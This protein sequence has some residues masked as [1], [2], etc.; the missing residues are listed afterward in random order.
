MIE[1]YEQSKPFLTP[2]SWQVITMK[3]EKEQVIWL[4]LTQGN[5]LV[6]SKSFRLE[7]GGEG[8]RREKGSAQTNCLNG[9]SISELRR[10][11]HGSATRPPIG[12]WSS[13]VPLGWDLS[14]LLER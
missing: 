12:P 10:K 2:C 14:F 5:P 9:R 8:I 6:F 7:R 11:D 1:S 13:N 4:L 3:E